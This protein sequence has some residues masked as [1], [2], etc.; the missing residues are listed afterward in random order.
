M[1]KNGRTKEEAQQYGQRWR[2][3]NPG[4]MSAYARASQLRQYGLTVE[5]YDTLLQKQEGLCAICGR[6]ETRQMR[7]IKTA[8]VVDHNHQTGQVRGL[9]CHACN[10]G[11]G[12]LH[13]DIKLLQKALN[14]LRRPNGK[15]DQD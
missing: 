5:E 14:Y 8:L 11:I 12:L 4:R 2:E 9:L 7:G 10:V 13:D 15:A 3:A 1:G 6:P